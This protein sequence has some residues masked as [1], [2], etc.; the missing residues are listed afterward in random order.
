VYWQNSADARLSEETE[1]KEDK[2]MKEKKLLDGW[3]G[4]LCIEFNQK[5]ARKKMSANLY[6][7]M[8]DPKATIKSV[9]L[10]LQIYEPEN[11]EEP[12]REATQEEWDE[13]VFE[14]PSI[15]IIGLA[16][17]AIEHQAANGKNFSA[18]ELIRA[19]EETER[20]TRGQTEW[21]GGIDCHH[22]FFEGLS[23]V[24]VDEQGIETWRVYWGS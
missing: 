14:Q 19:I 9:S 6:N 23:F 15:R 11:D 7:E 10:D 22:I 17:E 3:S 1:R 24:E 2:Q 12:F 5:A 8:V 13:V 20:Q 18:R 4:T 16:D 21:F